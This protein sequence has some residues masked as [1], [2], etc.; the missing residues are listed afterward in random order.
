MIRKE[1]NR[2]PKDSK[3]IT[4]RFQRISK[5][6]PKNFQRISKE[7]PKNFQR[8]SKEFPKNSQRI[9]QKKKTLSDLLH[10]IFHFGTLCEGFIHWRLPFAYCMFLCYVSILNFIPICG[11]FVACHAQARYPQEWHCIEMKN[12][13]RT[14][15]SESSTFASLLFDNVF[16]KNTRPQR[17]LAVRNAI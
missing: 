8:I 10:K 1:S 16:Q 6:F 14:V 4:K 3:S 9:P 11:K 13:I 15:Q 12:N 17:H 2:I 7:F 5:E